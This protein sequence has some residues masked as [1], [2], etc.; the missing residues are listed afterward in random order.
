MRNIR[1]VKALILPIVIQ[2]DG[3]RQVVH[4][5]HAPI[6]AQVVLP[7]VVPVRQDE[8]GRHRGVRVAGLVIGEHQISRLAG[9]EV[10]AV[11][12]TANLAART[13]FAFVDVGAQ[14]RISLADLEAGPARAL[15]A[16]WFVD[17]DLFA[18]RGHGGT[19]VYFWKHN[20]SY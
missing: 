15:V 7:D 5:D 8:P 10:G 16:D 11:R 1:P 13:I 6:P 12:V 14:G 17:A 18:R 9:A 2:G 4:A 20:E 3:I 19:F